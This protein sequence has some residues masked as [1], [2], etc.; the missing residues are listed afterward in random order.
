MSDTASPKPDGW[1]DTSRDGD[2]R[3]WLN[4]EELPVTNENLAAAGWYRYRATDG[5]LSAQW[6]PSERVHEAWK[7]WKALQ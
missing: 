7:A 3:I 2:H 5:T 6:L 1:L 4:G